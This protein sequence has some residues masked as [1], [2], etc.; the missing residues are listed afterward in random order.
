MND[1]DVKTVRIALVTG[2]AAGIGAAIAQHLARGGMTVVVG[3]KNA[4]GAAETAKRIAAEGY[5]ATSVDLEVGEPESVAEA[6]RQIDRQL[7]GC[8]VLVNNAGIARAN[9]FLDYSLADWDLVMKVNLTG[10]FLCAQHAAR[11]MRRKNWGRIVNVASIAAESASVG[12][13]AYG[14]SKAA[15]ISLTRQIAVELAQFGITANAV[16]PGRVDTQLTRGIHADK[17]R[18]LYLSKTPMQRFGTPDEIASA[19]GFLA[20]E[21]SAYVTGQVLAVD[22]GFVAGGLLER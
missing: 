21:H 15:V 9:M 13:S 5:S 12:N 19:V 4:E 20:S 18:E 2:G 16:A 11:M 17:T 3:D 10:T 8:D 14:P 6:F 22:G 7:G 1:A